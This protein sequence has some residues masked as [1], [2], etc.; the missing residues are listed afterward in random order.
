[1]C[2]F[3][4]GEIPTTSMEYVDMYIDFKDYLESMKNVLTVSNPPEPF[5]PFTILSG[6]DGQLWIVYQNE[7]GSVF[8]LIDETIENI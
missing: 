2:D 1:M 7:Y 4:A 5:S 8:H 6:F 3:S